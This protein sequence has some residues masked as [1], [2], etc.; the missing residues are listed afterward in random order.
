MKSKFVLLNVLVVLALLLG[1]CATAPAPAQPTAAPQ[2]AAPTTAPA[3]PAAT[4]APKPAAPAGKTTIAF[5]IP[6]LQF[7]FFVFMETQVKDEATKL[8]VET[9][10][11]DG[12]NQV[13][14]ADG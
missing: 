1:A 13:H 12:Q 6:G 5:S 4:E 11:L 3:A 7:P 8:G 14:Q 10:T 2:Q 9:Q